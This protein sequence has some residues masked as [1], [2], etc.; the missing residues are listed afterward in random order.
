MCFWVNGNSQVLC[1]AWILSTEFAE[2]RGEFRRAPKG[3]YLRLG[4][5]IPKLRS[6][7]A[8]LDDA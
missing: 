6:G 1:V 4:E 7:Y 2:A 5:G 8:T 3:R